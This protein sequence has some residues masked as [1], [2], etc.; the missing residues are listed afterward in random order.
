MRSIYS[1]AF[2]NF[3]V[4]LQTVFPFHETCFQQPRRNHLL[5]KV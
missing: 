5:A 4:L 1:F 2:L 3:Q